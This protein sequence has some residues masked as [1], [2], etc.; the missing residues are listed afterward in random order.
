MILLLSAVIVILLAC[1]LGLIWH[2][3]SQEK[4]EEL[5]EEENAVYLTDISAAEVTAL[6][7]E[8]GAGETAFVKEDGTWYL[9]TDPD[10]P[11]AQSLSLIHIL[12]VIRKGTSARR[13]CV[14]AP[15]FTPSICTSLW[16]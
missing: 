15:I 12:L 5:A 16:T 13:L 2:N 8:A 6:R 1:Y 4:A 14:P 9:E 11:L 3:R 10:F 7:Y